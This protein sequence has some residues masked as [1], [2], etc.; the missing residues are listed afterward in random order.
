MEPTEAFDFSNCLR[1]MA[2]EAGG[3]KMPIMTS[4]GTTIVGSTFKVFFVRI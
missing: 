3:V 2:M 1:N 4:T